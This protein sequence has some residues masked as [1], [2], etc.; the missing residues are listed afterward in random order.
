MFNIKV[1][2]Q[3]IAECQYISMGQLNCTYHCRCKL[4]ALYTH[5]K[6]HDHENQRAYK[7]HPR[8]YRGKYKYNC[9]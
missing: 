5:T 3:N 2:I 8:L 4:W 7:N 9:N 1:N 6:N